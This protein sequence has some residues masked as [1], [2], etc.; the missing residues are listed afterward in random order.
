MNSEERTLIKNL[1]KKIDNIEK[2]FSKKDNEA[3]DLILNLIKKNPNSHYYMV[4]SLL[5]Q[6]EVI[7]RLNNNIID[8]KNK[9]EELKSFKKKTKRS[10]LSNFFNFNKNDSIDKKN[11]N[12]K[13]EYISNKNNNSNND[14]NYK[15]S[16]FSGHQN[17]GSFLGNALQTAAG[18]AG[19]IAFGN[20]LTSLF[21]SNR[22][23]QPII[24][25]IHNTNFFNLEE[26]S[27]N[28]LENNSINEE[29][30]LL[31]NSDIS[32]FN[33]V[34]KNNFEKNNFDVTNNDS[35]EE[36]EENFIEN[37]FI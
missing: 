6:D 36:S 11:V 21:H 22:Y 30:H 27:K 23:D 5:V 29:D 4:Q 17:N 1:F 25:D 18:V 28:S 9:I 24:N 14:V 34:D 7:L 2:K 37:D 26:N 3:N 31:E 13:S 12:D 16:C 32:K 8:L 20:L 19:G 35:I 10:F 15:E 33:N